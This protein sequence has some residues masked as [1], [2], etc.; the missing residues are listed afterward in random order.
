MINYLK[1]K[2]LEFG[3]NLDSTQLD[4]FETFYGILNEYNSHTNLISNANKEEVFKKHFCDSLS[5]G[6]ANKYFDANKTINLIDI[7]IGGGFPGIPLLIAYPNLKLLAVDSVGKKIKFL[8]LLTKELAIDNRIELFNGR[9]EEL[10]KKYREHFDIATSRAVAH[11]SVIS[12]YCIPYIKKGGIFVA[13]KSKT[14]DEEI[15]ESK[16]ALKALGGQFVDKI[17]YEIDNNSEFSRNLIIISKI[18][19]TPTDFPRKTGIPKK[20]PL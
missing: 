5:L 18:S 10:D 1:Q 16:N 19:K 14:S 2:A 17:S 3:I 4:S 11:L 15:I 20:T 8:D 9:A 7:G 13:Y 12:E 6:L